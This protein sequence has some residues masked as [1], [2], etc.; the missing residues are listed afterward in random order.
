MNAVYGSH[1]SLPTYFDDPTNEEVSQ[2]DPHQ[3]ATGHTSR[4]DDADELRDSLNNSTLR[5]VGNMSD[6]ELDGQALKYFVIPNPP[7]V[8][9]PYYLPALRR[10]LA[11]HQRAKGTC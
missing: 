11:N 2:Y 5:F 7:A 4:K 9:N 6:D 8:F 10:E 1:I 3:Y